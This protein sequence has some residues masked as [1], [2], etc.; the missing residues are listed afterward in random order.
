V[1]DD[2]VDE[3]IPPDLS[4]ADKIDKIDEVLSKVKSKS[5]VAISKALKRKLQNRRSALKSR[6]RK[7]QL[8]S[9][10]KTEQSEVNTELD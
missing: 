5:K 4:A 10:L 7:S 9:N 1:L 8:I 2:E 6:M 3:L